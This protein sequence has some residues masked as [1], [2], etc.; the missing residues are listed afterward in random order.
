MRSSWNRGML[1]IRA[2]LR[3]ERGTTM[4]ITLEYR[5]PTPAHCDVAV[6]VNGALSGTLRLRQ[7]EVIGFQQIVLGG[8]LK[9]VD[10][11]LGRGHSLPK[12]L[13]E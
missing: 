2:V 6:F 7:D 3:T 5:N 8:C 11:F 13:R 12:E 9:G 1:P 4:K 10:E